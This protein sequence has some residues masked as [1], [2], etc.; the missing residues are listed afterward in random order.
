MAFEIQFSYRYNNYP[1]QIYTVTLDSLLTITAVLWNTFF[2][3]VYVALDNW[4][5]HLAHNFDIQNKATDRAYA[6]K[7]YSLFF[8]STVSCAGRFVESI[9][10]L[11]S[12]EAREA[13]QEREQRREPTRDQRHNWK[14]LIIR[15]LLF[16][17]PAYSVLTMHI[18]L[19]SYFCKWLPQFWS[20]GESKNV[21]CCIA[22][23]AVS[24]ANILLELYLCYQNYFPACLT[25]LLFMLSNC[26]DCP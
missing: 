1:K 5:S 14:K 16:L 6:K 23:L 17:P 10:L 8:F 13:R 19:M 21:V 3:V 24:T 20:D 22:S 26:P 2:V 11:L 12:Q 4:L 7:T 25:L 18:K 15:I 9:F